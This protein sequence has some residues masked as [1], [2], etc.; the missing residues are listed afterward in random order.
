MSKFLIVDGTALVFRGFYAI[1]RLTSPNGA[2]TH[3]ILGFYNIL[4]RLI[5]EEKPDYLAIAFDRAEETTRKKEYEDYKATRVK[6]PDEL[7]AQ[8]NP[9]K[10]ILKAG[11]LGLVEKPGIEADDLIATIAKVH[12]KKDDVDVYIYSSD[13]DLLQLVNQHTKV[14]KPGTAKTGN[15]LMGSAQVLERYGFTPDHIPDYKGLHGDPSDNLPGV[16]GVGEKTAKKLIQKY[17]SLEKIYENLDEIKGALHRNL[18]EFKD[19]AFFCKKLATLHTN[20]DTDT[21]LETY[22]IHNINYDKIR[23]H[24]EKLGLKKLTQKSTR[25]EKKFQKIKPAQNQQSLF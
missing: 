16:K 1:P 25:L 18:V 17:G 2:P 12:E 23:E 9:T 21:S 24:F 5:N 4:F 3:A 10:K 20:I 7:Y 19:Q 14:L 13:L 22:T 15:K 6:A 11:K 8:I